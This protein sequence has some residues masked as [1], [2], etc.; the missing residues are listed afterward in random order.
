MDT[1]QCIE[2]YTDVS[3][4]YFPI[5]LYTNICTHVCICIHIC[6]YIFYTYAYTYLYTARQ[7]NGY[8]SHLYISIYILHMCKCVYRYVLYLVSQT[9]CISCV[10]CAVERVCLCVRWCVCMCVRV[11]CVRVLTVHCDISSPSQ[12][13]QTLSHTKKCAVSPGHVSIKYGRRVLLAHIQ[14]YCIG[15]F[16]CRPF[17]AQ[18]WGSFGTDTGLGWQKYQ[19][20]LSENRGLVWRVDLQSIATLSNT[21]TRI[22]SCAR[23]L[24]LFLSFSLSLY[25]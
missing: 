24:S 2:I 12:H 15:I 13:T 10:Y 4:P 25:E 21:H 8:V 22:L 1:Q 23:A 20:L 16:W 6:I 19:A 7:E 11:L 14:D 17:L 5:L 9:S 3:Y 18:I